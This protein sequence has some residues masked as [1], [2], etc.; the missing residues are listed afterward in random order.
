MSR[1]TD[2]ILATW[3]DLERAADAIED[4]DLRSGLD[5]RIR[6]VQAEYQAAV[7]AA[8][9]AQARETERPPVAREVGGGIEGG[10]PG[11]T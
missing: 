6:E 9:A 11:R 8:L 5:R 7:Q 1:E 2:A 4:P 3:R 10:E